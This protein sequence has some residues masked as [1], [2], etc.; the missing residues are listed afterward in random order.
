MDELTRN[1]SADQIRLIWATTVELAPTATNRIR[2]VG[3]TVYMEDFCEAH[4]LDINALHID[5]Y[6]WLHTALGDE[7]VLMMAESL[8]ARARYV[9]DGIVESPWRD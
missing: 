3:I 8:A 9:A 6:N 4:G 5:H 1:E 7:T 2:D